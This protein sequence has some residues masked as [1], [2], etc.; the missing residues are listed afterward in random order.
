MLLNNPVWVFMDRAERRARVAVA[1]EAQLPYTPRDGEMQG[2]PAVSTTHA[3][4]YEEE[5]LV[6]AAAAVS[7][8]LVHTLLNAA[9]VTCS[10][11]L[12]LE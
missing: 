3:E 1:D 10:R 8:C 7:N 12:R 11:Y 9:R 6:E 2:P 4:V 5:V